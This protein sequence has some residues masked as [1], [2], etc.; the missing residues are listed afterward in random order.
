MEVVHLQLYLKLCELWPGLDADDRKEAF[1]LKGKSD[2]SNDCM[3]K[4]EVPLQNREGQNLLRAVC[5]SS[6]VQTLLVAVWV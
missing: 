6:V 2:C 5:T 4:N 1:L 3:Q